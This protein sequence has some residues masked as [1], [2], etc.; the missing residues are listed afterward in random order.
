MAGNEIEIEV[1]KMDGDAKIY[2]IR[3]V[4]Y[5]SIRV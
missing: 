5:T 3:N 4:K 1:Y 2:A